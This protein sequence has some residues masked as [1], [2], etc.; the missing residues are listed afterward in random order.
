MV[1][2]QKPQKRMRRK[3]PFSLNRKQRW[4]ILYENAVKLLL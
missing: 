3:S 4:L 1:G 2:Y